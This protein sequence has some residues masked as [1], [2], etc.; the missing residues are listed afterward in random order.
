MMRF[1]RLL[2]SPKILS[3]SWTAYLFYYS[4]YHLQQAIPYSHLSWNSN[5]SCSDHYQY[6]TINPLNGLPA[7][8]PRLTRTA[9]QSYSN[10]RLLSARIR[11]DAC[12]GATTNISERSGLRRKSRIQALTHAYKQI[13]KSNLRKISTQS[14]NDHSNFVYVTT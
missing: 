5:H 10:T 9:H 11:P 2:H 1:F 8:K 13:A 12:I 3:I 14:K 6:P 7:Y 4:R